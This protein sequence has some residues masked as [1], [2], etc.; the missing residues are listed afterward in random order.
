[1]T[2]G[3]ASLAAAGEGEQLTLTLGRAAGAGAGDHAAG[4][5]PAGNGSAQR[6]AQQRAGHARWDVQSRAQRHRAGRQQR[7][8]VDR[9]VAGAEQQ[10]Q[11]RQYH[12][13]H[14]TKDGQQPQVGGRLRAVVQAAQ[15]GK[16]QRGGHP[17]RAAGQQHGGQRAHGGYWSV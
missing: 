1:V 5:Q 13:G 4:Q 10:Q 14:R 17:E 16:D 11:L 3:K 9:Q 8:Q 12:R 15:P 2:P 6:Q 7:R